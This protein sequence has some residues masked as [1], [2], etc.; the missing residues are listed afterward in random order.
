[1]VALTRIGNEHLSVGVSPLGAETQYLRDT[2]GRDWLWN[3][4]AD[5]WTGRSPLL[6]PIVGGAPKDQIAVGD[7]T[8]TMAKH[9]FARQSH[10]TLVEASDTQCTHQL[11]D[12][13]ETRAIYPFAFALRLTHQVAGHALTVTAEVENR[14]DSDMPFGFGFHPAFRWP[15]PGSSGAHQVVLDNGAEPPLYRL[16][17]DGL[18][19]DTPLPS[20]FEA[21]N[22]TLE[23]GL[24]DAD[25]MIFPTGAGTGLTLQSGSGPKLRFTWD[26]LPNLALWQKPRAPYI[27]LEPWHGTAATSTSGPQLTDRPH[28]V[29]LPAGQSHSFAFTVDIENDGAR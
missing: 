16:N 11:T 15:L 1:M 22:L 8:A 6:F 3:G 14:S 13:D 21:G 7:F 27:C 24:F 29:L 4:D 2:N 26:G 9:G 23:P 5:W 18:L 28:G 17:N 19:V 20:P 10:F 12:S 25:A